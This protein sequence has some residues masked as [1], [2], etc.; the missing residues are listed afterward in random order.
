MSFSIKR[1]GNLPNIPAGLLNQSSSNRL[2]SYRNSSVSKYSD[3]DYD[4]RYKDDRYQHRGGY[5]ENRRNDDGHDDK[6]TIGK[7]NRREDYGRNHR[8]SNRRDYDEHLYDRDNDYSPRESPRAHKRESPQRTMKR[9]QE[10]K[11]NPVQVNRVSEPVIAQKDSPDKDSQNE[12]SNKILTVTRIEQGIQGDKGEKG[13]KG[14]KGEDGKRG[15][16]GDVGPRGPRGEQGEQGRKGDEGP[17][18]MQGRPGRSIK[19]IFLLLN[20]KLDNNWSS[21]A[22]IPFDGREY[23]LHNILLVLDTES[24]ISLRLKDVSDSK[25]F[26]EKDSEI[27]VKTVGIKIE[28]SPNILTTLELEG[29]LKSSDVV[30]DCS[31]VENEDNENNDEN[32][33]ENENEKVDNCTVLSLEFIMKV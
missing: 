20:K 5:N 31:D 10:F 33:N 29:C 27:S 11:S 17:R 14:D 2:Y 16:K 15:E 9:P 6:Y 13:D 1:K 30:D 28:D 12:D 4:S 8:R 32:E 21:I 22:M 26:L 19:S 23:E 7:Y 3:S 25:I 24:N 18:G